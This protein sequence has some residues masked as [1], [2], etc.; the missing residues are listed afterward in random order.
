M[1]FKYAPKILFI[2]KMCMCTYHKLLFVS[3]MIAANAL[4]LLSEL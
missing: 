2:Y 3:L 4:K 1:F